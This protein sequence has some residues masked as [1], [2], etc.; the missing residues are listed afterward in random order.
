MASITGVRMATNLLRS[1]EALGMR[2][3]SRAARRHASCPPP[4]SSWQEAT[5]NR[6]VSLEFRD[7]DKQSPPP[8]PPGVSDLLCV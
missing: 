6:L 7:N 2:V 8:P 3:A 4:P 1:H 5:G